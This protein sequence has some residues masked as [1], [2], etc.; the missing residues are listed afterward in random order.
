MELIEGIGVLVQGFLVLGCILLYEGAKWMILLTGALLIGVPYGIISFLVMLFPSDSRPIYRGEMTFLEILD[1]PWRFF[2]G[3][4]SLSSVVTN[5]FSSVT[6]L[7]L[8]FVVLVVGW[9]ASLL[10]TY[11]DEKEHDTMGERVLGGYFLYIMVFVAGKMVILVPMVLFF[12]L[13]A[14]WLHLT[15]RW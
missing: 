11:F 15:F 10:F 13:S 8:L 14:V 5:G 9:F 3:D 4:F 12:L 7:L 1:M 6:N 2:Q